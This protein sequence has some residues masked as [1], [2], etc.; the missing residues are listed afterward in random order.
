PRHPS[1]PASFS[2][3]HGSS[4]TRLLPWSEETIPQTDSI[5]RVWSQARLVAVRAVSLAG[6]ERVWSDHIRSSQTRTSG[7]ATL[8]NDT[9][10]L[11]PYC[12]CASPRGR[13]LA[14]STPWYNTELAFQARGPSGSSV[15]PHRLARVASPHPYHALLHWPGPT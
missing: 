3:G 15:P 12:D 9:P 6:T 13:R 4:A 1:R 11:P 14:L 5:S 10:P 2:R 7:R 8:S